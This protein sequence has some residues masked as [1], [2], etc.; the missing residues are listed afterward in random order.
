[1]PQPRHPAT[2]EHAADILR[3]VAREHAA[4]RRCALLVVTGLSGGS[5]RHVGSLA[6]V[7]ETGTMAG[8]VSN[9]CIDADIVLHAQEV[10]KTREP[11]ALRYGK[12]SPFIDL[13]LPCGGSID[14]VIDPE[15]DRQ[16]LAAALA[17]LEARTA[18][19]VGISTTRG[20]LPTGRQAEADLT[21][22]LE[23]GLRLVAAGRGPSLVAVATQALAADFEVAY[24]SPVA[25]ERDALAALGA[26]QAFELVSPFDPVPLKAD[27]WTAVV[28]L[29][30][31]HD[32]EA[33]ILGAAVE[34]DAFYIGCL[35]SERTHAAR[36]LTLEAEGLSKARIDRIRGPIGVVP[37]MRSAQRLGP[38]VL[39]E[40]IQAHAT[41]DSTDVLPRGAS[42]P[43]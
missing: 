5:M 9:G 18:A 34:T 13:Q 7:S 8:Y 38:S 20:L 16:A 10:I 3:F 29:F 1:M 32:W 43:A 40:I 15:P 41:R 27:R 25:E 22:V 39:A 31:E 37:A 28:L 24:A 35:G 17:T 33:R 11:R 30:H 42:V 6:A 21:I 14:L 12:G 36:R 19:P 26:E 4:G 23:P 2:L